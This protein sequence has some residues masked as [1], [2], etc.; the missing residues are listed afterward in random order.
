[1][2]MIN[3]CSCITL[4]DFSHDIAIEKSSESA[5]AGEVFNFTCIVISDSPVILSWTNSRGEPVGGNGITLSPKYVEGK[6]STIQLSFDQLRTSHG[7]QYIC[8]SKSNVSSTKNY[9]SLGIL[10]EVESIQII[11]FACLLWL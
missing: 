5:V 11:L 1:M 6:K 4:L 7:G 3:T 2:Y 8:N 9:T 10:L